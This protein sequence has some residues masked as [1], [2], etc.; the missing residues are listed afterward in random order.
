M[1]G[2]RVVFSLGEQRQCEVLQPPDAPE[3]LRGY[4]HACAQDAAFPGCWR[5]LKPSFDVPLNM[6]CSLCSLQKQEE[7]YKLLYEVCQVTLCLL[8]RGR[9]QALT[10]QT[11]TS[12]KGIRDS[13]AYL[14]SDQDRL[15]PCGLF[16][17]FS[18]KSLG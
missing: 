5:V 2:E 10:W 17:V 6:G 18:V 14:Y 16:S 1:E 8:F 7:Q 15:A 9:G 11:V 13:G 12:G 3:A 4:L